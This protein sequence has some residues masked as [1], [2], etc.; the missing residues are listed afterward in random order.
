MIRAT[1]Q[2]CAPTGLQRALAYVATGSLP[3]LPHVP[4]IVLD[5]LL[6]FTISTTA[7]FALGVLIGRGIVQ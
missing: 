4:A 5:G 2:P 1:A 3:P 7:C 6:S